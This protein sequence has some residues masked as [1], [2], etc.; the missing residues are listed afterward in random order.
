M[1][2]VG[3]LCVIVAHPGH[4]YFLLL[5]TLSFRP[6]FWRQAE[7]IKVSVVYWKYTGKWLNH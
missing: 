3:L 4:T 6:F 1:S 7:V 5:M 2:R